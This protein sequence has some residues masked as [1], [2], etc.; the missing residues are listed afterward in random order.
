MLGG[1]IGIDLITA[2]LPIFSLW[3]FWGIV[4]LIAVSV[5]A[6]F[7]EHLVWMTDYWSWLLLSALIYLGLRSVLITLNVR[8]SGYKWDEI[9]LHVRSG[10]LTRTLSV[11]PRDRIQRV[12]VSQGLL[13]RLFEFGTFSVYTAG[14]KMS[15]VYIE[16]VRESEMHRLRAEIISYI[17]DRS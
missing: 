7:S 16:N 4:I 5:R 17:G 8:Y 11:V 13:Q 6:I 10:Y 12:Q 14:S 15:G 3:R 9:G 1:F 2:G